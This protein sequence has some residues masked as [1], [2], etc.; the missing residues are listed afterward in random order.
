MRD[1]LEKQKQETKKYTAMVTVYSKK[2]KNGL[3]C[4]WSEDSMYFTVEV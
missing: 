3:K 4:S 1:I 2:K